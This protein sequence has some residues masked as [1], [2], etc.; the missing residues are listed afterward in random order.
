MTRSKTKPSVAVV[1]E[2]MS[3]SPDQLRELVRLERRNSG[4]DDRV[5]AVRVPPLAVG[6]VSFIIEP[7]LVIP[8]TAQ[9]RGR[10]CA[11]GSIDP[12]VA[13]ARHRRQR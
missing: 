1:E 2:L 10:S 11:V 5:G 3:Q 8:G 6:R 13:A 12:M 4:S 7:L 9:Q